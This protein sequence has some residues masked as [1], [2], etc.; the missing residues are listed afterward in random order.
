[1][2]SRC[3]QCLASVPSVVQAASGSGK[4]L[5]HAICQ[6]CKT[7]ADPYSIDKKHLLRDVF[8]FKRE[9]FVHLVY[10]LQSYPALPALIFLRL[11]TIAASSAQHAHK[12]NLFIRSVVFQATESFLSVFLFRRSISFSRIFFVIT[13]F[14]SLSFLKLPIFLFAPDQIASSYYKITDLLTFL[15]LSRA[16]SLAVLSSQLHAFLLLSVAKLLSLPLFYTEFHKPPPA[17]S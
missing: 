16:L 15:L 3:T 14:S 2:Q 6:H 12:K 9:P 8:L 13:A 4:K 7:V 17:L 11:I 5:R 1:M 10:N